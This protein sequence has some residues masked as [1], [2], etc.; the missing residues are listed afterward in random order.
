[1]SGDGALSPAAGLIAPAVASELPGLRLDWVTVSVR[2]RRSAPEL[3]D[4]LRMLSNRYRGASVVA[5]RT[6]AI[7]HAYR[8]FFRQIGLDPDETHIPSEEAALARLLHGQF[9]SSNLIDD[10]LLIAVVE[11]GVPV[12]ALDADLVDAGGLG[13]RTA[14]A[15]DRLGSREDAFPLPPGRLVVADAGNVHAVLFGGVAPGHE[16]SARTNR[17]VLFSVGVQGVPA[18]HVEEALWIGIEALETYAVG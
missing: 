5:M 2:M 17:V 9:R 4:R 16:V 7:P 13:V 6:Q 12:W 10:A 15:G 18:I 1:V 8:S 14:V 11:T 3:R